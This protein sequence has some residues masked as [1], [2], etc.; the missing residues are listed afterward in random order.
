MAYEL[1]LTRPP[2]PQ[3][4]QDALEFLQSETDD[5]RTGEALVGLCRVLF[6]LNEF[7]YVD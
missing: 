1:A 3:E 7:V 6:N 5:E 4:V 2:T